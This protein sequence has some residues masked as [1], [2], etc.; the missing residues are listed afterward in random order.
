MSLERLAEQKPIIEKL[1]HGKILDKYDID[2]GGKGASN[3]KIIGAIGG[4][5]RN[6][7]HAINLGKKT[8]EEC[9]CSGILERAHT[10]SRPSIALHILNDIH[11]DKGIPVNIKQFMIA[12]LQE[13][14]TV[15]IWML[16]KKCH[17][18]LG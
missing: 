10:K 17:K 1:I 16:C 7:I 2:I 15:G 3:E 8:C 5:L 12:F 6:I 11:P 9:G 13:H 14:V 4:E 18:Q